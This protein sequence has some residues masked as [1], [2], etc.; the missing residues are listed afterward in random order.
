MSNFR[1]E[2]KGRIHSFIHSFI[3]IVMENSFDFEYSEV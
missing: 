3:H 2:S 1:R